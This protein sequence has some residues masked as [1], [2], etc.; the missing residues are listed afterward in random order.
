MKNVYKN[1]QE[2]LENAPEEE[3][4]RVISE[5]VKEANQDQINQMRRI[6]NPDR[7]VL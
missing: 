3:K 6:A 2:F 1:L 4:K 5:I 7:F